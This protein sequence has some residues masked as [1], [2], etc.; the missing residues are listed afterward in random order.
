[1]LQIEALKSTGLVPYEGYPNQ[2]LDGLAIEN[3]L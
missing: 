3:A 1:M 2:F